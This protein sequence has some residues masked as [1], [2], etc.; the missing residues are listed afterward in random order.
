MK[1]LLILILILKNITKVTMYIVQELR[2]K[3]LF[4]CY[5]HLELNYKS[6]YFDLIPSHWHSS[7]NLSTNLFLH[8]Q[9]L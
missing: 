6:F 5:N 7:T 9:F 1:I 8:L 2:S 4:I 3:E